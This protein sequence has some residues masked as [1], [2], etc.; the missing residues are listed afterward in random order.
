L[1][2]GSLLT[3]IASYIDAK[4]N[5]GKWFLRLDDADH[6]REAKNASSSILEAL[7]SHGFE[8][9]GT[10]S[11]QSQ[12]KEQ[13]N[14]IRN[15]LYKKN[16]TY[17]CNCSRKELSENETGFNGP[18]YNGLCRSKA[19]N[20]DNSLRVILT[21]TF[22]EFVDRIQGHQSCDLE[23]DVGD[24]IVWRRD[25]IISYHLAT[26]IDDNDKRINNVVRG[27]D[28]IRPTF[29]QLYLQNLL[30]FESPEYSHIPI[31]VNKY[32]RKL[33]KQSG[34]KELNLKANTVNLFFGL[35][36]LN[37]QPPKKLKYETIQNI[38]QWSFENWD[39]Q[40]L[41]DIERIKTNYK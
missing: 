41:I 26:V 27:F 24:F 36:A 10:P 2:F 15:Y 14:E 5:N 8:W 9:D 37:Q 35:C 19:I 30:G 22:I 28:L 16:Y 40:K 17:N 23:R 18:I 13:Y 32:N 11:Y 25:N 7:E 3:A 4:T 34:A 1:H 20:Q 12:S 29:C 21:E 31:A 33:S 39:I 38:W 6:Y